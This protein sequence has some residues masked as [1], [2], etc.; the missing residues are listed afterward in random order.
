MI[1]GKK[2][3]LFLFI[4]L[5]LIIFSFLPLTFLLNKKVAYYAYKEVTYRTILN[6]LCGKEKDPQRVS[7]KVLDFLHKNLYTPRGAGAVDEDVY[8]DLIRGISWCDQRAWALGTLLGRLGIDNRMVMT[9]N[10]EGISNHTISELFI[11]GKWRFFDPY[12]GM[13]IYDQRGELVSYRDICANPSLFYL[14]P[15]MTMI[16]NIDDYS[17]KRIKNIFHLY[18]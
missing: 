14:S 18:I 16:K 12:W 13:V 5:F 8:N 1:S 4:G 6:N 17:Y 7:I 3:S 10:P 2:P 9:R 11:N 15:K